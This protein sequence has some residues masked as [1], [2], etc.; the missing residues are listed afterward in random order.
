[1]DE[2]LSLEDPP[3]ATTEGIL[4]WLEL[5]LI[6]GILNAISVRLGKKGPTRQ[7]GKVF[8][9]AGMEYWDPYIQLRTIQDNERIS[10]EIR[11]PS[12]EEYMNVYR[13]V[14]TG[15]GRRE[16][17]EHLL[18]SRGIFINVQVM[19]KFMWKAKNRGRRYNIL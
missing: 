7:A 8:L 1:M 19:E 9:P 14:K 11:L 3:E 17:G 18:E 10:K 4:G 6:A 15:E 13:T 12:E 5:G 16:A 2:I